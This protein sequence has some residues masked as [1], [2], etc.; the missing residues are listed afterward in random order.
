MP[1]VGVEPP[2]LLLRSGRAFSCATRC[3]SNLIYNNFFYSIFQIFYSILYSLFCIIF[4]LAQLPILS[5]SAF[6]SI[7]YSILNIL[8][9]ILF[10]SIF[11]LFC[12][13][14]LVKIRNFVN[15]FLIPNL[16]FQPLKELYVHYK[17]NL[18]FNYL[19]IM[20]AR[21]KIG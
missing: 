5:Y 21:C 14:Y 7:M 11:F 10:Y 4:Y 6:Y 19:K 16:K 20:F 3:T 8:L 13:L 1:T 18:N 9:A 15:I 12:R 17:I 2:T